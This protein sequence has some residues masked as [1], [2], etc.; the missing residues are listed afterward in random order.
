M[1]SGLALQPCSSTSAASIPIKAI[2]KEKKC[3]V[4]ATDMNL[5]PAIMETTLYIECVWALI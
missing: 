1:P 5:G 3:M 4:T 2:K